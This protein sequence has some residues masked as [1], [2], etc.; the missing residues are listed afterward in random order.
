MSLELT[1]MHQ[2]FQRGSHVGKPGLHDQ[3]RGGQGHC[4]QVWRKIFF[5]LS[6]ASFLC[7]IISGSASTS[8][9][10]FVT[11]WPGH[12]TPPRWPRWGH[13]RPELWWS[14]RVYWDPDW[15]MIIVQDYRLSYEPCLWYRK[16]W[17][18]AKV[19]DKAFNPSKDLFYK[20]DTICYCARSVGSEATK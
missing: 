4:A 15:V 6:F 18:R 2:L 13:Q 3:R 9:R 10:C 8:L 12:C 16:Q 1:I 14:V 7:L 17:S 19:D 11:S 20:V 5:H